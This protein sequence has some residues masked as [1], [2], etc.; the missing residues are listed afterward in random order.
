MTNEE[1]VRQAYALAEAKD[2]HRFDCYPEGSVI[3][4]QLGVLGSL[5]AVLQP[6]ASVY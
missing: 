1:F 3:L 6:H 4:S 2:I 5:D